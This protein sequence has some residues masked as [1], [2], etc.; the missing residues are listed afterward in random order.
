MKKIAYLSIAAMVGAAS[1]VSCSDFLD[2][3]NKS[4]GVDVDGY[5]STPEGIAAARAQAFAALKDVGPN[6]DIFCAGTDL[7]IPVRGKDPGDYQR[8]AL[9]TDN[10]DL[11]SFYSN[12]YTL[13]KQSMFYAEKAGE[14]AAKVAEGKFLHAYAYY[15]LTQQ[16]GAV[17]YIDKYISD[18]NRDYPKL[19]LA[20]IYTN[21]E[22][23]L[24]ECYNNGNL[25]ETAHDGSVSKQA[26]ASLLAK[27]YLSHGWDV[28]TQLSDAAKGTYSV[29]S[30]DNFAKAAEWAVK[31]ING[32]GLTQ[33][34]EQKW[35]PSNDGN[36]EQIFSIQYSRN[37]YPGDVNE[38]GHGL[39]NMFANYYDD[40]TKTGMK[41]GA[42]YGCP[43]EKGLYLWSRGDDRYA[44]TFMLNFYNWDGTTGDDWSK[45]G[46]YG[47]YNNPN[48]SSLP[49]AYQYFPEYM[50]VD[51]VKAEIAANPDKY[52]TSGYVNKSVNVYLL[53]IPATKFNIDANGKVSSTTSMTFTEL[54]NAVGAG[55]TVKKFDDP[56]SQCLNSD[57]IDYRPIVVLDLSDIYLV[58][59]EAYLM[60]DNDAKALEYLNAVR[61]RAH[62]SHL[63]SFGAYEPDYTV[64]SSFGQV[65]PLDVILD[66]RAREL[67]G[68]QLRWMD[69]RRTKQ[70]VRYN[71][72]YN[73]YISSVSDMTGPD[74]NIRWL[75]PLPA[76]AINGNNS[77]STADQNPGY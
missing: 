67:Y 18:S 29:A 47:Y 6:Y 59:A 7:Y 54:N 60:S 75:R 69:L 36:F 34:F 57:K 12:C 51:E 62:A 5:F 28:D 37:G 48:A 22:T 8:Y 74:G 58:A 72:A 53:G 16:F 52:K 19:D 2:T 31:G 1:L 68:Q 43:S 42:S 45:T 33:S 10:A 24:E 17:P 50:T 35:S 63:A 15:L 27:I 49:V 26:V 64:P 71:V 30:K 20:S 11:S 65:T 25:P 40:P 3:N 73:M 23:E 4:L 55:S 77:L 70:L 41:K 13:V 14:D 9:S 39:Q 32:Q 56:A 44:G 21:L 38:G 66:E 61:D 46:Y 76:A